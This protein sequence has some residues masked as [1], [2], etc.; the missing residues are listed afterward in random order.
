MPSPLPG[1]DP[2]MEDPVLWPSVHLRLITYI[3]DTLTEVLP[4]GYVANINERRSVSEPDR[5]IYPDASVLERLSH[6]RPSNGA[7]A[8]AATAE[9][10]PPWI[11]EMSPVEVREPFLEILSAGDAGRVVTVLEILSPSNKASG[12]SGRQQYRAKQR[13]VLA[14]ET[15]L[16]K[17]DLLRHGEHTVAATRERV[18]QRGNY[19]YIVSLSRAGQRDLC[20]VWGIQLRDH[21]PRV[22]IPLAG[23]DPDVLLDLQSHFV[24]CYDRGGYAARIDYRRDPPTALRS[25]DAEWA[26]TLLRQKGLRQ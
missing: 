11:V 20:E 19:D 3:G 1:M 8:S 12:A 9:R 24:T 10:D 17:I 22:S 16:L 21:L 18:L 23:E 5:D 15:H 14:S 26:D 6:R 25:A 7:A 13:A 2:W 4:A